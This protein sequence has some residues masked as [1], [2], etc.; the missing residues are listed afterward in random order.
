MKNLLTVLPFALLA[1][2]E[3]LRGDSFPAEVASTRAEEEIP[4]EPVWSGHPV[5]FCLLTHPPHQW[6]AYYGA[7][8]RMSV[9]QRELNSRKWTITKLPSSLGWDSHNSVT[10]A[11]DREGFLHLSGNM[12]VAPLVYFRSETPMDAASLKRVTSMVGDREGRVTYPVVL[13]D[14]EGRL[15]F[16]YRDGSSGSGDDL[17]NVYDEKSGE[18]RRLL[19]QPLT[20]G[21]GR[22]NAYCSVPEPGPDDRFHVVWV[23]RDTPDCATNHDISYARSEDLVHWTDSAGQPLALPITLGSHNS[24]HENPQSLLVLA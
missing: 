24:L 11:L 23:W 14:H 9:A 4:V 6:V 21:L 15:I 13:S 12:H 10:M 7:K 3:I 18:W 16:R 1:V 5:G 22:M 8:R 17:Y 19:D 2:S 20:S